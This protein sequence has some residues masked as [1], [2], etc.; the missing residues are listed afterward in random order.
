LMT[1]YT[2][3][4]C[5]KAPSFTDS[6]HYP[7]PVFVS[8]IPGYPGPAAFVGC[9]ITRNNIL[10]NQNGTSACMNN[11]DGQSS[12]YYGIFSSACNAHFGSM[13]C[14]TAAWNSCYGDPC[15]C[16]STWS[17]PG[18]S[19]WIDLLNRQYFEYSFSDANGCL[20][21]T[22]LPYVSSSSS[23][24]HHS[25]SSAAAYNGGSS[26]ENSVPSHT[27]DTTAAAVGSIVGVLAVSVFVLI[28]CAL[29]SSC[30]LYSRLGCL[31][32]F[33]DC[34]SRKTNTDTAGAEPLTDSSQYVLLDTV[35]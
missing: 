21:F 20:D 32:K 18:Q 31:R 35:G 34:H 26:Q 22:P 17:R 29:S 25:S 2:D 12:S 7:R 33:L 27:D 16:S 1:F 30:I 4:G 13:W 11:P 23:V 3:P 15:S 5:T 14:R 6:G 9:G 8:R 24:A 28:V 10:V 19:C